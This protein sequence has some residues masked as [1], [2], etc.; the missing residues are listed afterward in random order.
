MISLIKEYVNRAEIAYFR[1]KK[2][3]ASQET[4]VTPILF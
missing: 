3:A 1:N 2:M 4:A